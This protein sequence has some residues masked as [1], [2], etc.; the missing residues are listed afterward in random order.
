LNSTVIEF[1]AEGSYIAMYGGE[2]VFTGKF[3]I[4]CVEYTQVEPD[5]KQDRPTVYAELIT[6]QF[7]F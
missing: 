3:V 2:E 6:N 5:T 7:R 4:G 1:E